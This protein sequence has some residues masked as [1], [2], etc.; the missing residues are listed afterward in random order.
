MDTTSILME[1]YQPLNF[2]MQ[3]AISIINMLSKK[4]G[5]MIIL[6][7]HFLS[8]IMLT[9]QIFLRNVKSITENPDSITSTGTKG[10]NAFLGLVVTPITSGALYKV[11]G[12]LFITNN[13]CIHVQNLHYLS[14]YN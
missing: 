5:S 7:I 10:G 12:Y 14:I 6:R 2:L 4:K 9:V 13:F 3:G 11:C 1:L 8:L